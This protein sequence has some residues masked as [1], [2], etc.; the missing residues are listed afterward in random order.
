MKTIL[1]RTLLI[2]TSGWGAIQW[3]VAEPPFWGTIFIDPD[4]ITGSDPTTFVSLSDTGRGMRQMYDRRVND[5]VLL[6]PYLF[7]ARYDDGL[8]IEIQVNPEF[9][10]AGAAMIE[11]EKY[12]PI[13]GR[14]PTCLRADV[15][16]VWMHQGVQPFG[17]GNNN[18][19]IHIGQA[20]LYAADGILE[21]VLVHEAS[22]SSLDAYHATASGW[23]KAQESD[24]EF[25]SLYARD[26]PRREDIAE[27]FLTFLA[28]H[29][30]PDRISQDLFTTISQ[31]IPNRIA[32]F[33]SQQ[34][35]LYPIVMPPPLTIREF[36]YDRGTGDWMLAWTSRQNRTYAVDLSGN[37]GS[38][39]VLV[40]AISSQGTT[41]RLTRNQASLPDTVFLRVR[42]IPLP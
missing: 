42:E 28:V 19:L 24:G 39:E 26:F 32:Y 8:K 27:S 11:A 1:L 37:L 23:L 40:P 6:N 29:S 4:I 36:H 13:I 22:H 35:D 5:W 16:T 18:L 41:T 12:A 30:R 14:L 38:W 33:E 3:S 7:E 10:S 20:D 25:I 21:E 17:G 2:V 34:L 31:T 9:G 15:E